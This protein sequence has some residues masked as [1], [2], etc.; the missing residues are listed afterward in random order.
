MSISIG[1]WERGPSAWVAARP[2]LGIWRVLGALG[3]AFLFLHLA[4]GLGGHSLDDFVNRWLYDA[5]ELFAAAACLHRAVRIRS[6]RTAWALL[7]LGMLSFTVGDICFDFVYGGAAPTPSIADVFFLG[8][9]PLSYA[10]VGLMLRARAARLTVSLWLD[11]LAAAAAIA[12][13]GTAIVLG[14]ELNTAQGSLTS[15]LV[16]LAY[17]IGDI[18]LVALVVFVFA[19]TAWRPGRAWASVGLAYTLAAVGDSIYLYWSATGSY[20]EG[21]LLDAVWPASMLLLCLAAWQPSTRRLRI[22]LGG[23][24][25]LAAPIV[26][27]LAG[28]G[29]LISGRF[30]NLNLPA[31]SLAAATIL[32]V[33]LRT[34]LA[35]RENG[36]LLEHA[37]LQSLSD[38]LT[39]LGNRRKLLA[40][41]HRAFAESSS[42]QTYL[43]IIFDMNGFKRYN[44]TFGHPAGDVLLGRL[45]AALGRVT[46]PYGTAYRLGGD[47]FCV[48]ATV[49]ATEAESLL[50]ASSAA[51]SEQGESFVVTASFGAVF[52]PDEAADPTAA[53]RAADE[54]LYA[55]KNRLRENRGE[56]YEVL[57]T[58]LSEREPS[59]RQHVDDVADLS[60][61]VG[62]RLGLSSG[63]LEDLRL[64]AELHDVGK[65]AIPDSVLQKPGLLTPSEQ[66]FIR[67]HTL[68][69]Q[70][71]L[72]GSP[73]LRTVGRIVRSTH[74]RWDGKGYPDGLR[75]SAILVEARI[76]AV[77][78]AYAAITSDRPYRGARAEANAIDELRRCAGSQFDP[79]VVAAFCDELEARRVVEGS[80]GRLAL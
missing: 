18:L 74:E 15:V 75:A 48:L 52:V 3:F 67:R 31:V 77:C 49:S 69:G 79:E 10:A 32:V 46:A 76:I 24:P 54:R 29:I 30:V 4:F 66:V 26:C 62:E 36:L 80:A 23:R 55:Q 12:A 59:L 50:D 72:A 68:I 47:E 6:D 70:R 37:R 60:V 73:S 61:A 78:D 9:Y 8:F 38:P 57:L 25:L 21:T 11:G 16:N 65:L 2:A 13:V 34:A 14:A 22:E 63:T 33:L 5:L 51:L 39:G 19:V 44:D 7:G 53:L 64:A 58:A 71:I 45:A 28:I 27:G 41:L 42:E 1:S 43:L 35:L 17:P 40:D 20:R 56:P